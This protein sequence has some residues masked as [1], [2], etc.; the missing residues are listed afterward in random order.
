MATKPWLLECKYDLIDSEYYLQSTMCFGVNLKYLGIVS[1]HD[2]ERSVNSQY[3]YNHK[4][5]NEELCI[6]KK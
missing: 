2:Q 3:L 6:S 1:I 5:T 4:L